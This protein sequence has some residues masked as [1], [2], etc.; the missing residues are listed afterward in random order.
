MKK[1]FE[2][3]SQQSLLETVVAQEKAR[4]TSGPVFRLEDYLFD[5]QLAFV[6]DPKRFKTAV[7]TRRSGKT[8]SCAAD[9]LASALN[10]PDCVVIYITLTRTVAKRNIWS[11][12]KRIDRT[13]KLGFDFNESDL[14]AR[15]PNESIV[16][17]SGVATRDEIEKFRGLPIKKVYLDEAQSLPPYI[18]EL[19]DEVLAP[20]LLDHAGDLI[21]IGTPGPIPSGYFHKC[22]HSPKW[23]HH[24]WSFFD[25]HHFPAL[26]KGYTHQSLLDE[27]LERTGLPITAPKIQREWFGKWEK[28]DESLVFKYDPAVNDWTGSLPAADYLFVLGIDIGFHDSDALAVLA[29]SLEHKTTFLVEEIVIPRQGIT[30]L[31]GQIKGL[32]AKYKIAKMVMDTGGLGKKIAEELS[33]R[34][35][36]AVEP[37]DK[38]RKVEFIE[39]LNDDLRTG[40]LKARASSHFAQDCYKVEW[41]FDKSTPDKRRISDRFHSDICDAVLYSWRV[42]LGYAAQA[43]KPKHKWGTPEWALEQTAKM[44][45]EAFEHFKS[46]EQ[47]RDDPFKQ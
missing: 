6:H 32:Q 4:L 39:L 40:R 13:F 15:A 17:L 47:D 24:A 1:P 21:L 8:V 10:T 7:T 19:V 12:L 14:S 11:Q 2:N 31:V 27:E 9:L 35:Q 23:S 41:D 29:W 3:E 45:E 46:M 37:A 18:E 38:T 30:E 26:K 5:K 22:A 34:H 44:E 20:A 33:S 36:I 42:C 16:Y 25:N 43:P 28:D